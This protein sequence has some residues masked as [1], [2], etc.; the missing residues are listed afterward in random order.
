MTHSTNQIFY[1]KSNEKSF[2]HGTQRIKKERL[3]Q[4]RKK[5]RENVTRYVLLTLSK[6]AEIHQ[7]LLMP[8]NPQ[9]DWSKIM[10]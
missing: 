10:H 7:Y 4:R 9:T 5:M 3:K 1:K 2:T 8:I 6:A